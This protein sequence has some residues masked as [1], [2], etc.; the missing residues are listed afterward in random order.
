MMKLKVLENIYEYIVGEN[1]VVV[2]DR[3]AW[4]GRLGLKAVGV[5]GKDKRRAC[6]TRLG[7]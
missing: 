2:S 7:G 6:T 5:L 4:N 3:L 1:T